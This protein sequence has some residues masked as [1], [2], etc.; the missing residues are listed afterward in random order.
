MRSAV[1][2]A[3]DIASGKTT[4]LAQLETAFARVDA[5][6]PTLNAVIWQDRDAALAE[7]NACNAEVAAGT[8]RG[9][10]HGVPITIKESFDLK[11]SP[12]TW[13]IPEL[14]N[15]I[16]AEDSDAVRRLRA[17]GGIIYGKTNV[18][19][20]L[21]EWQSFNEVYGS[22]SNPWD[23]TRTAGGS[24]GGSGVS[25][26]TGMAALEV[27]S[28]IG[29][30]IRNPAHYNGVFGLKPTWNAISKKGHTLNGWHGDVDIAVAGPLARTADDLALAFDVLAGPGPF[31]ASQ[32][33]LAL[34]KDTR[35]R[36]SGFKIALMLGDPEAPV[37]APYLDAMAAF[38]D[39][40]E[41]A[42]ATVIRDRLPQ[43]D[44]AAHFTLYLKL[45]GAALSLGMSDE[46]AAAA[47]APYADA[48]DDVKRIG[49]TRMSGTQLSHREWLNLDNQRRVARLAFD[50]FFE[51]VDV[52]IA[53]VASSA[54]FKKD[55][56][57]LRAFRR[58]CVNNV[59][60]LENTQLFWSG[61]SGVVGLPS[62]VGPMAQVA[63]LPVGY[64]AICGHGRDLTCLA[65]AKAVEREI[66]AYTPPQPAAGFDD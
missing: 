51:D 27:G 43:I 9:P 44:S 59:D 20:K 1:Q 18:P 52:I 35:N 50:A 55:E 7:A 21:V 39:R 64:Q 62:V 36:L 65:F 46:D 54:A 31:D 63:G 56:A 5:L 29:S 40:L 53:P 48:P 38:A 37:D 13:G 30:S 66:V 10:L 19:L 12:T 58:F 47:V 22:T 4:A 34:P 45:L 8:S 24:S 14:R 60:Q 16:A 28:D 32:W 3:K 23:V 61:Y 26:A 17:A 41:S 33:T 15:N 11:G 25:V 6:N 49:G 57:G 42:G 2:I